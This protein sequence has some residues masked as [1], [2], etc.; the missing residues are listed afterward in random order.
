MLWLCIILYMDHMLSF[1]WK[2][3]VTSLDV[4]INNS[5]RAHMRGLRVQ[6]LKPDLYEKPLLNWYHMLELSRC[7]IALHKGYANELFWVLSSKYYSDLCKL[8]VWKLMFSFRLLPH[9]FAPLYILSVF[10]PLFCRGVL[11]SFLGYRQTGRWVVV[12]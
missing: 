8:N 12:L 4:G 1:S 3:Q 6:M 9:S 5:S 10:T 11:C 2:R 7:C